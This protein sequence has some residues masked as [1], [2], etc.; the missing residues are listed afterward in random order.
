MALAILVAVTIGAGL[1]V[2]RFGDGAAGDIAGDAL[3]AVMIYLFA[4]FVFPNARPVTRAPAAVAVC[5][6][7]ELLQSTGLPRAWSSVFPPAGL[8]FGTGFDPRDLVVYASAI[9]IATLI[10]VLIRRII[11]RGT[12]PEG[13]LPQESAL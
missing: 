13:A 4:V 11:R 1:L 8:V 12:A 7:I 5:F 3:Y 2:H 9:L 6:G 10:D